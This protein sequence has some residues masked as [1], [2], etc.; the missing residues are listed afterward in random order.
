MVFPQAERPKTDDSRTDVANDFALDSLPSEL[1]NAPSLDITVIVPTRNRREVL[2]TQTLPAIFKQEI[3][4]DQFEIVVVVDGSTDGTAQAVRDMM[5]ICSLRV[6]EQPHLGASAA[7]NNGIRKARGRLV[8]FVDDDIV[9]EPHLFRM[10]LEAHADGVPTVAY[11]HISIAPDT[12][13]SVL[14]FATH[15]WYEGYYHG[16]EEQNGLNLPQDNFLISN[17]SMPRSVLIE[18]GGFDEALTAKEDYELALRLWKRGLRFA[19]LPSARAY[20]F[21][22]K[23]AHVV[24]HS[25][26]KGF[27]ES[28]ILIARK[29]PEYRPCS[30]FA[31]L[32]KMIWWKRMMRRALAT[33]PLSP[34][35]L[36]NPPLWACDRLSQFP[37]MR[38]V[39]SYF[40]GIGRNINEFRA[41]VR[42]VG[43]WPALESEFGGRLPVLLY[44][45]VGPEYPGGVPG[46]TIS[47]ERFERHIR[48]LAKRGYKGV[49]P[50]DWLRWCK[51]GKGLPSKPVLLTFD[52]GYVDLVEYALPILEKYGFGAAVYIVTGQIG[53]INSWDVD[54]G[55]APLRLMTADQIRHWTRHG[56]EFGAH[57]RTHADLTKLTLDELEQEVEGSCHDLEKLIGKQ[58][59]SFAYPYGFKTPQ[60]EDCVRKSFEIA[61]CIDPREPGINHLVTDRH[62]LQRSMVHPRYTVIDI[63]SCIQRGYSALD[64]LRVKFRVRTR[65][66]HIM[67]AAIG[68]A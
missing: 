42:K 67:R 14:K 61:F 33:F 13:A 7:R 26:G 19:Y 16:I 32:G 54:Q 47:P 10:H 68:K 38:R 21:F 1:E 24:L 56:I 62:L 41:A 35:G 27:G 23:P 65:L 53:G 17:S 55:F 45:H 25:D 66:K 60:V 31:S 43:S 64:P 29:H 4:A 12:P 36:L 44:H 5:P 48:W 57:S 50:S 63:A 3:A 28:D 58:V 34:V 11:G 49:C 8:L 22:L 40:L 9:C 20:E 51:E 18:C 6:I 52:D 30:T 39:G 37:Q 59:A 46:L 15:A 2:T